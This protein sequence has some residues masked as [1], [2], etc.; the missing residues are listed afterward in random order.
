MRR[1]SILSAA[2][3]GLAFLGA[4]QTAAPPAPFTAAIIRAGAINHA[5]EDTLRAG[6]TLFVSRCIECHTLPVVSRHSASTW[7]DVVEWMAKRA[8]LKPD[9]REAIVAYIVAV[10][11]TQ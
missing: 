3:L 9:E 7:P 4:C 11:K 6:R 2:S 1:F 10:R 8:N 5:D